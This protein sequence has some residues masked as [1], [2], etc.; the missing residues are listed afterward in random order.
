MNDYI[1]LRVDLTPC[2]ED[3]TDLLAAF[4]ADEGFES[5]E[6]DADG[7]TAFI[8][9]D[10]YDEAAVK[11]VLDE[12]PFSTRIKT[13]ST[14]IKGEDWN[15]EWEKNY[16]KPIV[17]DSRC[18]I[19]STFH[20]DVPKAEYDI[21]IDPKMAFGTGYH[22]TTTMMIRHLLNMDLTGKRVTDMGTGTGILAILAMMRGAE[23]AYGIEI[24]PAA[25]ANC[26]ENVA[27]NNVAV[28]ILEGDSGRLA[29]TPEADVFLANI[30][31]NVILA[32][33]P[34]FAA[35]MKSGATIALSGFYTTDLP[36]LIRAAQLQG[37]TPVGEDSIPSDNNPEECWAS[38]LLKKI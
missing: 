19:H 22:A 12:F 33:L 36:L 5:F 9:A 31:R 2:S 6:P 26:I 10:A 7:L 16:F 23:S 15:A 37:L 11:A 8:P 34:R 17:I 32:D 38:L 27:L 14:L 3:A 30:N 29:D 24:D 4:L 28:E 35:A 21:T 18:V 20:T 25:C 1:R 13:S